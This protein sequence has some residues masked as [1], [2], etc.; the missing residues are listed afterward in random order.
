MADKKAEDKEE[1]PEAPEKYLRYLKYPYGG[2]FGNTVH[3]RIVEKIVANPSR[4]YRPKD[5]KDMLGISTT[6]ITKAL[7][8]LTGL[9]LLIKITKDKQRPEYM[10]NMGSKQ[11][12]AL[13]FLAY[14][15]SDDRD[16]TEFMDHAIEDYCNKFTRPGGG[17]E[18]VTERDVFVDF[19]G[20]PGVKKD[21]EALLK[22]VRVY[23][24]FSAAQKLT[25]VLQNTLENIE[26]RTHARES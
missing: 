21:D 20:L 24:P 9:K 8:D 23:M 17:V 15:V 25:E 14:A 3:T 4:V 18:K 5:F 7:N 10:A 6:S 11:L 13:T 12:Y 22:G 16:G 26:N 19:L 2:L 1:Y